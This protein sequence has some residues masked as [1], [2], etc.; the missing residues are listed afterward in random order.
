MKMKFILSMSSIAVMLLLSSVISVMEYRRMSNY[1]SDLIASDIKCLNVS[2]KLAT[3]TDSYNLKVLAVIGDETSNRLPEFDR[4]LF[5]NQC[6]SLRQWMTT[7]SAMP[8]ADSVVLAYTDYMLTSYEL[9]NVISS[10]FIDS[11]QWYF[12]RLQ[13]SFNKLLSWLER[14]N[15]VIYDDLTAN[16]ET[17]QA[18]FYRSIVPGVVSV[19]AG[20][21]LVLL[22]LF[23][24]LSYFVNP[25]ARMGASLAASRSVGKKYTCSFDGDDDLAELNGAIGELVEE[26]AELKRRLSI[27]KSARQPRPDESPEDA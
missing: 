1:V 23:F 22:L 4:K 7:Q 9:E 11:R 19:A 2:Q 8:V 15:E 16:S 20:L 18:S 25:V 13:P 12:E 10:R 17:F 26:N 24:F 14:L 3:I 27:M 5:L 21:L 6:D